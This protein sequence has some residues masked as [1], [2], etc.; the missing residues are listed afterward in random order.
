MTQQVLAEETEFFETHKDELAAKYPNQ[1]LLV[2]GK[3]V[4]GA[5][6]TQTEA[7][8]EGTRRFDRGPFL[9]RLAGADQPVF[10]IPA[11]S[12]GILQ[13]TTHANT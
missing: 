4:V 7:I 5:F 11:L 9:V 2:K 12:L 3:G 6:G 10:S 1:H 13:P 8:A